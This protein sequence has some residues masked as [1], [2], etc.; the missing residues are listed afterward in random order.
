[1]ITAK[2]NIQ[3]AGYSTFGNLLYPSIK[4]KVFPEKKTE[5]QLPF[6]FR[7][8]SFW[9]VVF[10][11]QCC[12]REVNVIDAN[13]RNYR[14]VNHLFSR[15]YSSDFLESVANV[16]SGT[17]VVKASNSDYSFLTTEDTDEVNAVDLFIPQIDL[18]YISCP[19]CAAEYLVR[20]RQGLPMEPD[21]S[22]TDGMNGTLFIDEIV[23]IEA[24][25]SFKNFAQVLES[26]F[27][28]L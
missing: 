9:N 14:I 8:N 2:G 26:S 4:E 21:Q 12:G 25:S 19:E 13:E 17:K 5:N 22:N 6:S 23:R 3:K 24:K 7:F 20:Y 15:F 10:S 1:M 11:C 18:I 16:L 28:P 27:N